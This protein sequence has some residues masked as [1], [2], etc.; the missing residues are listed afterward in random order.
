MLAADPHLAE[1]AAQ[2]I[3]AGY[4]ELPAVYDEVEALGSEAIVHDELKP[5]GTF[6]DLKHLA[7]RKDTNVALDFHLRRGDVETAFREAAHV[8]EH[9]FRT[10]QTMHTP[11]EP[12]VAVADVKN[13][14]A[15]IHTSTQSPSFVRYEIARL[16]GWPEGR[17]QVK[18]AYLGGGFGA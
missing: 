12:M 10:Q 5:A 6:V 7:G 17:L 14:R 3:V 18:T 15:V 1:A 16:L 13:G 8:F 11:F 9:S 2:E 4:E